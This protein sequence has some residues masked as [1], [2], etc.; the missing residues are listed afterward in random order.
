MAFL[1]ILSKKGMSLV[2]NFGH[3]LGEK[4]SFFLHLS[5]LGSLKV[6]KKGFCMVKACR[7]DPTGWIGSLGGCTFD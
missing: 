4:L 1:L 3:F 6:S 2:Q 7:D 5:I